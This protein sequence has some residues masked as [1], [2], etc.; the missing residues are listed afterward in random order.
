MKPSLALKRVIIFVL[1]LAIAYL[2]HSVVFLSLKQ[3]QIP[4][5]TTFSQAKKSQPEVK[6]N[7]FKDGEVIKFGIYSYAI[8][9]GSGRLN[10]TGLKTMDAKVCR[11]IIFKVSTFSVNDEE[12]IYG[13]LDFA[14]PVRVERNV[15]LFGKNE[16]IS[17]NYEEDNKSVSIS[18]RVNDSSPEIENIQSQEQLNNVLLL[19]YQLRNDSDIKEG[20]TYHINLPTQ[21][22]DLVVY[23]RERIKVPLG[24]FDVF[25]IESKPPKYKIWIEAKDS[26]I[27]VKIQGLIAGGMVYLAATDVSFSGHFD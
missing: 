6:K 26:R 20:K 15:T 5:F 12:D 24:V 27:P 8:R 9:V 1:I 3:R 25:F 19:I 14:F 17:E 21:K 10:Y 7:V 16:V 22:F 13:S 2:F 11:H 23:A 4:G 18:K